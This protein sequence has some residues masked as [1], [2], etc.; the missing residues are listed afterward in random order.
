[1]AMFSEENE[2]IEFVTPIDPV[3]KNVEDWMTEVEKMMKCSVRHSLH[4]AVIDYPNQ[5]RVDW[6]GFHPGMCILNGS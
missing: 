6:A 5:K 2:K 4:T 1:M 3:N